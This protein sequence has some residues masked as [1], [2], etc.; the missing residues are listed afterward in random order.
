MEGDQLAI[1]NGLDVDVIDLDFTQDFNWCYTRLTL[2]GG[3]SYAGLR[4]DRGLAFMGT[5]YSQNQVV[6]AEEYTS[7]FEGIGPSILAE[8]KRRIGCSGISI[9]GGVRGTVLFGRERCS[10]NFVQ[11]NYNTEAPPDIYTETFDSSA[12]RCRAIV[13][14]SIGV[15][16]DYE[17]C[18][19]TDVFARLS[20][21]GQYWNGFGTPTTPRGDL[22]FQG[23]GISA[24]LRR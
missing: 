7:R 19:G 15:Q 16:Y 21:E 8:L 12:N 13:A 5:D 9:V 14:A 6:S 17:V 1:R 20:W 2:G 11:V 3:I 24:G 23:L 10:A 22:G 18:C 4:I